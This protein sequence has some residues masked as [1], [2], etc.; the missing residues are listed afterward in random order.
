MGKIKEYVARGIGTGFACLFYITIIGSLICRLEP[1]KKNERE[2]NKNKD[3]LSAIIENQE[4]Y[5][6]HS[7]SYLYRNSIL[8]NNISSYN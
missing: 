8:T 4:L 1:G 3:K 6:F 7:Q 2:F 5:S